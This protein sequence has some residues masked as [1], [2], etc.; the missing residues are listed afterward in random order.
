MFWKNNNLKLNNR[1]EQVLVEVKNIMIELE[2]SSSSDNDKHNKHHKHTVDEA[3]QVV[4]EF[5]DEI[6]YSDLSD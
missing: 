3:L 2:T 6:G 5:S 1:I 4:L